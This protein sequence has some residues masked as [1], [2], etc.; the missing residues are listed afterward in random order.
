MAED[1]YV[2]ETEWYDPQAELQR[3]Y[4]LTFYLKDNTIEM[5]DV[6]NHRM[7]LK[8]TCYPSVELS[9]LF[10]GARVTIFSRQLKLVQY[11][12]VFTRKCLETRRSRTLAL[13]KPDG[14]QKMGRILQAA[15]DAGLIVSRVKMVRLAP[16][17][18]ADFCGAIPT[19][20]Q[21]SGVFDRAVQFMSS[22]VVVAIELVGQDAVATWKRI[23]GPDDPAQ[24]KAQ[25]PQS[26]HASCGGEDVV[27]NAVHG[28]DS[29]E[30]ARLELEFF[31]DRK[32]QPTA[33]VNHCSC[34]VIRPHAMRQ[35]G[36]IIDDIL[37]AGFEVSAME[38]FQ[39][40]KQMAQE[41]LEVYKTA[42][43][44]YS[45]LVEQMCSGPCLAMEIRQ[46]NA[47]QT[48]RDLVGPHDPD[49]ARALRP[50]TLRA[51]Y[52]I[53]RVKNA[54]HCTDLPED[55]ALEVE[56]FF[57]ILQQQQQQQQGS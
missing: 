27:Q 22:D 3:K 19:Y 31:F 54:V 37:K 8:R 11:G 10:I 30:M 40:N 39:L 14:Y 18:T 15:I 6:K 1:R 12:D 47:V 33:L 28:S 35:A 25:S 52:G 51:K 24:A 36:H 5:Y 17:D 41:F 2:F 44:E 9:D 56:F 42:L 43:P 21:D 7:F 29:N 38:L 45:S 32:W 34:A 16:Q 26:L 23:I 4:L 53:D 50:N 20:A 46:E 48:F 55:G 49:I 57:S 13:V